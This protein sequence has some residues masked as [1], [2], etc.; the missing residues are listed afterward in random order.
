MQLVLKAAFDL[1]ARAR[2]DPT[3][4]PPGHSQGT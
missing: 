2:H 4:E 1:A 3:V